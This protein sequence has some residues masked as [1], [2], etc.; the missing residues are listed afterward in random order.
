MV[1]TSRGF[2]RAEE[3]IGVRKPNYDSD[4]VNHE[5]AMHY[6]LIPRINFMSDGRDIAAYERASKRFIQRGLASIK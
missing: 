1:K 2:V 6:G 3:V 5:T 4:R